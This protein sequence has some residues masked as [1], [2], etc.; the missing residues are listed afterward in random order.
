MRVLVTGVAGRIGR[1]V[2][3]RLVVQPDVQAVIGLD[4]RLC[5][6]PVPGMRFVR[7]RLD[8]PEWG[9]LLATVDVVVHVDALTGWPLRR[10]IDRALVADTQH[11]LRAAVR[12]GV[13]RLV[14]ANNAALYGLHPD[15]PLA[16][17][18]PVRGHSASRYARTRAQV[19]DYL[20]L[21][22]RR[23]RG[24]V[25]TRLRTAWTCGTRYT[26]PARHFLQAPVLVCGEE[27]RRFQVIHEDD[28]VL[29]IVHAVRHDLPGVYNVAADAGVSFHELAALVDKDR[30]CVPL[31]WVMLWGW[32]GWRW[33]RRRTPPL[34]LRGLYRA[35][36]VDAG[37]L[38]A[39]GWT[40][41]H[42]SRAALVEALAAVQGE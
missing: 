26:A 41:R 28:L 4:E 37:K 1:L 8:Q 11:V 42:T 20:D 9:P 6:P 36:P 35:Q 30:A 10:G 5:R 31:A 13:P 3:E 12:A 27:E 39:T 15:G 23:A 34:W 33:L 38:R 16:E 2:A 18:A 24:T 14:V 29:A 17:S 22:E 7:A 40:P 19:A 21:F 32:W 25:V